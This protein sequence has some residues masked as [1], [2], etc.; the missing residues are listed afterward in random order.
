ME[1]K[2]RRALIE[3]LTV[4]PEIAGRAFGLGRSSAYQAIRS[5]QLPSIRLGRKIAVPTAPLRKMLGI[6]AA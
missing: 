2:I 1:S 5:G 6:E 3:N 4:P